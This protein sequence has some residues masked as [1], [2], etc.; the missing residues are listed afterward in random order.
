MTTQQ[1]YAVDMP[2]GGSAIAVALG[3]LDATGKWNPVTSANP[4]PGAGSGS[5]T[6]S[7]SV[8]LLVNTSGAQASATGSTWAGGN[9]TFEV[10]GTLAGATATLQMLGRDG[11]TWLS[12]G[13]VTIASVSQF[14]APA[15]RKLRCLIAGGAPTG[16]YATVTQS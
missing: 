9:G 14:N 1:S 16:I 15:G 2:A 12:L 6:G 8:D 3:F 10:M 5:G 11:V 13:S 4:L 7:S